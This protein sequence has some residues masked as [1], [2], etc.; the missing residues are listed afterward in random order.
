MRRLKKDETEKPKLQGELPISQKKNINRRQFLRRATGT[1][2]GAIGFPYIVPSS[3]LGHPG[4]VAPSERIT[5]GFIGVG[6]QGTSNL[7]SFLAEKDCLV[8]AVCDVDKN[9]LQDAVNIVNDLYGNKD[10]AAY[11]DFRQLLARDDIDAVVLSLPDH[12]HAIPAIEAARAGKDIYGEKPLSHTF[13]EGRAICQAVKRYNRVWQTGS[14]QRSEANFRFA[15]ELVLN[16]RIGK[17]HT[18]E[19][20][21]PSG[22]AD[23]GKTRGQEEICPPPKELD[24]DLWLGPAP[25]EPYCPAR[26]HKNWR[27]HLDYGGGQLM[28]WIG[29]HLD[30]AHWGLGFDYTGPY[31]IEGQGIYP[32]SG[33]WNAATTYRLTAKYPKNVTIII[34]GGY[35]NIRGGTKWIGEDGWVWVSREY[36]DASPQKLLKE[37]FG[38]DEIHLFRSPGHCR[39]FLDCVK[40][41]ATT[42]APCEVAHRSVTPGHLGQIA[43]LL[44]R[45]IRF[46]PDTE[47]IIGDQ[48]ATRML[49]Y[50]MRSPWHL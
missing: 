7:N 35:G 41:R 1:V 31:E 20:G 21:L 23:Y 46:N 45:K 30:I 16:G 33:L 36:M 6:W 44:G 40:S 5:I 50:A 27:W 42:V 37:R 22:Y 38:S 15:C 14:W 24:Y 11:H 26:V 18:V 9:H 47:E 13:N 32:K 8:I 2:V 49:G 29:H 28:D 25:Y 43:M 48:T 19:V 10:C 12:W 39:N 34:A 3:V 17:V 4:S